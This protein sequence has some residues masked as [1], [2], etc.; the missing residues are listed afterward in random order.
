[1][2]VSILE[3]VRTKYWDL[4]AEDLH[5]LRDALIAAVGSTSKEEMQKMRGFMISKQ[6]GFADRLYVDDIHSIQDAMYW[7]DIRLQEDDEIINVVN[8]SGP[9]TRSGGACSY[10]SIDHYHQVA[11]ANSFPQ[12]IGHIFYLN[13]P[14]GATSSRLDY[15]QAIDECR[16]LGKPTIAFID[17]ICCSAGMFIA[18]QCD[19]IIVRN[20]KNDVGCIGTM[21]AFY[22]LKDGDTHELT[23]ERYV[24]ITADEAPD[25]NLAYRNAAE[26]NYDLMK[27]ELSRLC[28]EFHEMV[29]AGR[30]AVT[31]DL[32]TGKVYAADEVLGK[33][34]DEV[35]TWQH[36]I[37][38]VFAL[39][40]HPELGRYGKAEAPKPDENPEED[41]EDKPDEKPAPKEP[42]KDPEESAA[43]VE[44][45]AAPAA[46]TESSAPAA[47]E[48]PAATSAPANEAETKDGDM[49]VAPASE[50]QLTGEGM[51]PA[52]DEEI[53][54]YIQET[55][56][57][58]VKN[59][60]QQ[61]Q[62]KMDYQRQQL[63]AIIEEQ[64][65]QLSETINS[66]ARELE[67]AKT[68][69][70]LDADRHNADAQRIAELTA[71]LSEATSA[72]EELTTRLA[73]REDELQAARTEIAIRDDEI[74]ALSASGTEEPLAA[75]PDGNGQ[76]VTVRSAREANN[77]IKRGMTPA[78]MREAYAKRMAELEA[79]RRR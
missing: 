31:D 62:E 22:T 4:G 64:K 1:M 72:V 76:G 57:E 9:I 24:E 23:K 7:G 12:T 56:N 58:A 60:T 28:K 14:G 44:E 52:T 36:A 71:Q 50:E 32:L 70:Q 46:T 69:A 17:G 48:E 75:V 26:G 65:T 63:E 59:A 68:Q 29:K 11:L 15:K 74:K 40:A 39:R 73:T 20:P 77:V 30:P 79:K 13:T 61:M 78:E 49:V 16:A 3:A 42:E 45:P 34:V 21:A 54:A 35:G 66:Q 41:P 2:N 18:S 55:V 6:R 19:L 53:D 38:S 8:I 47:T 37:D 43:H 51:V 27:E 5:A 25:K 10:G 33:L 67:S